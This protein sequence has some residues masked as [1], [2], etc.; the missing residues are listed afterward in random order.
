MSTLP[1]PR[2]FLT[3]PQVCDRYQVSAKTPQNWAKKQYITVFRSDDGTLLLDL[4]EIEAALKLYGP[5]KMRT[6]LTRYGVAL[7]PVPVRVE[8]VSE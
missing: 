4:D 2:R 6:G 1:R 5:T 3:F 8:A 7:K